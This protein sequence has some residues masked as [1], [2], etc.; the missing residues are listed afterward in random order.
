MSQEA[1]SQHLIKTQFIRLLREGIMSYD[2]QAAL[3]QGI[4]N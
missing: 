4:Y 3:L 1:T 2:F